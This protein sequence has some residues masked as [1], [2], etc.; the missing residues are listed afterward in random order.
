[1]NRDL[2]EQLDEMGPDYRA[3]VGRL[4][5]ACRPVDEGS[6]RKPSIGKFG[7]LASRSAVCLVA[8]SLLA[9]LGVAV[10]FLNG[11]PAAEK[12]YT[13]RVSDARL[14]YTLAYAT[15]EESVKALIG[16]QNAD[17]SWSNDFQTRQNAA[18]LRGRPEAAV[19]YKKA[20]RYLRSKGLEPLS[21]VELRQ[22]SR[23][24]F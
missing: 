6:L 23:C 22:R 17:G 4:V 8:A 14:A 19:A 5:G 10:C 12:V 9:L 11:K 2:D 21:D 20:V 3:V 7:C 16:S 18:A 24:A 1:M 13:V 15:S